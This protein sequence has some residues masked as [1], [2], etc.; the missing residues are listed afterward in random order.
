MKITGNIKVDGVLNEPEWSLIPGVTDFV[1]VD[2]YQGKPSKFATTI[3]ILYNKK[4]LYAG[5]VC[6]DPAGKK[7]IM[8]TDFARDFDITKHDL[9]ELAFDT[10]NDQRNAIA[11]ATNA[12]GVQ[13]DLLSFDDLYYDIDWDGLWSVRT[14]RSDS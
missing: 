10:F 3:K 13:R 2:P 9:V 5:I 12:Y 7:A 1:Q 8:A 6:K 4:Y 11:F 14:T